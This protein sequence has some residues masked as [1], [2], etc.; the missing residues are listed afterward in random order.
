MKRLVVSTF[1]RV[2]RLVA[3]RLSRR[4]FFP[5]LRHQKMGAFQ[6]MLAVAPNRMVCAS[7]GAQGQGSVI[8]APGG[9]A[10]PDFGI[11]VR[12]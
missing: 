10:V 4:I 6:F 3:R 2:I 9:P 8:P 7:R 11:L 1:P 12:E 5:R